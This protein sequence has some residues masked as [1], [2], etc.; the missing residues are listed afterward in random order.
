MLIVEKGE[1]TSTEATGITTAATV[2]AAV[3]LFPS[4]VAVMVAGPPAETPVTSPVPDTLATPGL[5]ELHAMARP[6]SVA[7]FPSSATAVS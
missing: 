2:I 6:D 1:M 7:P 3:P 5:L 4:L